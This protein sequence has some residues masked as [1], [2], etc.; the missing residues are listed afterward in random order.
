MSWNSG[1]QGSRLPSMPKGTE[2]SYC[3]KWPATGWDHVV[4]VR[5]GGTDDLGNLVPACWTCNRRKSDQPV[6]VWRMT[7]KER[8]E[9][10]RSQGWMRRRDLPRDPIDRNYAIVNGHRFYVW[11]D[12]TPTWFHPDNGESHIFGAALRIAAFGDHVKHLI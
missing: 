6:Q 8:A 12:S 3:H 9:W 10:L 1:R 7:Q 2:C 4:P 5:W 11:P